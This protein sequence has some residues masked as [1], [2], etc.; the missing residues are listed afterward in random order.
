MSDLFD[1]LTN[2]VNGYTNALENS[3]E[4]MENLLT[5]KEKSGEVMVSSKY[6]PAEQFET[7]LGYSRYSQIGY[8]EIA[9]MSAPKPSAST[10]LVEN[11]K[12]ENKPI[13]N[14]LNEIFSS[15][16]DPKLEK[17][18]GFLKKG[19]D[20][21]IGG[22]LKAKLVGA[23]FEFVNNAF[24]PLLTPLETFGSLGSALSIMFIP[25]S[26]EINGMLVQLI[27][28]L[29]AAGEYLTPIVTY[30]F[31]LTS[32]LGWIAD[33]GETVV[34]AFT[35]IQ[36]F[37]IGLGDSIAE[38]WN[39]VTTWFDELGTNTLASIKN[40][41]TNVTNWFEG[42]G[43]NVKTSIEDGWTS[44]TDWFDNLGTS[45]KTSIETGWT[46]VTDFFDDLGINV[47]DSISGGWSV[48]TTWF[49]GIPQSIV[50]AITGSGVD[51]VGSLK[52]WWSDLWD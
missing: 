3:S 21:F 4:N 31:H 36:T 18:T 14:P 45:V 10:S 52:S 40:G 1:L 23:G 30:L 43:D 26:N 42:I 8:E 38:G 29:T 13:E 16:K 11:L 25:I 17:G 39:T 15:I 7:N 35:S 51:I 32:P 2:A 46:D 27:P 28:Y 41:W 24:A 48:V 37:F 22:G 20:S 9:A 5:G 49:A 50:D 47:K 19:M 6:S 12:E 34:A 44:V 33:N